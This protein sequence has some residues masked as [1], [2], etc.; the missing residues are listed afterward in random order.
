MTDGLRALSE[1]Q[2]GRALLRALAGQLDEHLKGEVLTA[3][4]GCTHLM[5]D[6]D[7][8]SH[9]SSFGVREW[10]RRIKEV[11]AGLEGLYYLRASPRMTDQFN[12]VMGFDCGGTL[13]S[14][15]A[16]YA[17]SACGEES[18]SSFDTLLDREAFDTLTAPVRQ[19]RFCGHDAQLDDDPAVLFEYVRAATFAAPPPEAMGLLRHPESWIE[20]LPGV[21]LSTRPVV[22]GSTTVFR[23]AGII[24]RSLPVRRIADSVEGT[25]QLALGRITH[26]DAAAI[27][28]W[29][30]LLAELANRA[31]AILVGVPPVV[32]HRAVAEPGVLGG[33]HVHSLALPLRCNACR[34]LSWVAVHASDIAPNLELPC[35][36]CQGPARLLCPPEDVLAFQ[37]ALADRPRRAAAPEARP[38]PRTAPARAPAPVE[39][40]E[41][42]AAATPLGFDEKYEVL[43]RIGQGGMADVFLVRQH[44]AM[45]FKRL[46]VIKKVRKDY[47][48]D[49]R[50]LRLFLDE[51]RL[52][53]RIEHPNV[54][55]VHD[56]GRADGTFYMVLDFIHGRSLLEAQRQLRKRRG[57][58]PTAIAT[59]IAA[60]LC[61]GLSYAHRPDSGGRVLV[62]RDV[63]PNNVL[64]SFDGMVKLVDFGL[65]GYHH[66]QKDSLRRNH[67]L[68]NVPFIPP[69]VYLGREAVPQS[70]LWGVGL[71]L[72]VLLTG[73][74][75]FQRETIEKTAHAIVHDKVRRPWRRIPR[76]VFAIINRALAKAPDKR[77]GTAA[78]MESDLR[79]VLP[80]LG[81]STDIGGW[82]RQLF[83]EQLAVEQQFVR[84]NNGG[85][86]AD[87]L[88]SSTPEHISQLYLRLRDG[89][90]S[91]RGTDTTV[92]ERPKSSAAGVS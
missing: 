82:L 21:R 1:L 11:R 66:F 32:M 81:G 8:V 52:A 70:D 29:Q 80:K 42:Q 19:C 73:Q 22:V 47:L 36:H 76:R 90:V 62:H 51:A 15:R 23:L 37:R 50:M 56:L 71:S 9:V 48:T 45:G 3:A 59:S 4:S 10:I 74:H 65:A 7:K 85:S 67:I 41:K 86:L 20:E 49:D 5:L 64:V 87:A 14:F 2:Q 38:R 35:R 12:M 46:V 18:E 28:R 16:V 63:T 83:S 13:L 68:G 60:D 57:T 43:C 89:K 17:C 27:P 40:H 78:E 24:D 79:A 34:S 88:L 6:L 33:V 77:Y 55:R 84:A 54:I 58:V 25:V 31:R 30:S 72:Y 75:P 53:A 92:P 91:E 44:G 61:A 69:E 39:H 26:F